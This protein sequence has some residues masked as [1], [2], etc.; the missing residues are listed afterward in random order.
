MKFRRL[1]FEN[2]G[3]KMA[4]VAISIGLWVTLINE[5]EL[6]TSA[7]VPIFYKGLP[8]GI[9]IAS[10]QP[11]KIFLEIRGP[12]SR[13][14]PGRL[15]DTAVQLDLTDVTKPGERTFTIS[16]TNIN[17]PAGVTF[18]RAV[19][20]QLRMAF[21]NHVSKDVEVRVR[22]SGKPA[23]GWSVAHTSVAPDRL[24]IVGPASRV[25]LID[26]AET[27]SVDLTGCEGLLVTT[28][29]SYI[30]DSQ[31]RFESSPMV[32]VKVKLERTGATE[33]KQ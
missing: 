6:V 19:P 29:H 10:D 32:Q 11:D 20:S 25:A 12:A 28:V 4:S 24:R 16:R 5:P 18:L 21:D 8:V 23:D 9:E 15:S 22:L 17:L 27:D 26:W 3:W 14:T 1:I 13:L 2:F 7:A 31:V 30:R 33:D